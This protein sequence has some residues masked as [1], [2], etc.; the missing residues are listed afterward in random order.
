MVGLDV[1][2]AF[3]KVV[4]EM[5]LKVDV[6]VANLITVE[7][8][9]DSVLFIVLK[10][11]LGEA[12]VKILVAPVEVKEVVAISTLGVVATEEANVVLAETND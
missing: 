10:L 5:V 4:E 9:L 7:L 8:V 2:V 3:P 6:T 1:A 11:A 12:E